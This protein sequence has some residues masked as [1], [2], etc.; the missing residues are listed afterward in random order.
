MTVLKSQI[1]RV[2]TK[3][4]VTENTKDS[5]FGPGTMG[6]I[7]FVKGRDQDFSNVVYLKTVMIRRGK[8][9]KERLDSSEISTPIFE[10]DGIGNIMPDEAR[11][12]Y[13]HIS[14]LPTDYMDVTEMQD[15][16]FLGWMYANTLYINKLNTKAKYNSLWPGEYDN[17]L[18]KILRI[19]EGYLE[20]PESIKAEYNDAHYRAEI[21]DQIR[22]MESSLVR[23]AVAYLYRV[24]NMEFNAAYDLQEI[25]TEGLYDMKKTSDFYEN[26][27]NKLC[28][29]SNIHG[30]KEA[31][32]IL[33]GK[34]SFF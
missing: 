8:T 7:S 21:I 33:K 10:L 27:K 34:D 1:F 9:G 20:N 2:G 13:V 25:N 29:L 24:A 31:V 15:I 19:N 12:Y 11:R 32:S 6:Y 5:L 4:I 26:K 18:N 14:P 30:S 16:E 3:F 28:S 23:C 17:V 22:S